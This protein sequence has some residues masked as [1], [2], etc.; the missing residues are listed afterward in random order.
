ML[1]T[2][3]FIL[4]PSCIENAEEITNFYIQ[5]RKHFQAYF[6]NFSD[7]FYTLNYQ[8][9]LIKNQDN[10]F[11]NPRNIAFWAFHKENNKLVAYVKL[12]EIIRGF[13]QSCFLSYAVHND[14][15]NL[16]FAT[17]IVKRTIGFAFEDLKLHRIEANIVHHN[18]A[19]IKVAEK[20][21]FQLEGISKKYLKIN[22]AWQDHFRFVF[23]NL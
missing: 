13:F 7:S 11:K 8:M 6:P 4:K 14:F 20:C 10:P 1:E 18:N 16:G 23:L 3:R 22:N 9:E 19:S 2:N 12:S 17:E 21:G 5:N 15:Q